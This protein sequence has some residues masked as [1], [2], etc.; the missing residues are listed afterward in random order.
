MD[1]YHEHLSLSWSSGGGEG[2]P[3]RNI[4]FSLGDGQDEITTMD[5]EVALVDFLQAAGFVWVTSV[6]IT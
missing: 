2:I 6:A 4:N 3:H 1:N 5:I